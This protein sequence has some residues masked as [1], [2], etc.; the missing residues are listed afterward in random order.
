MLLLLPSHG[1]SKTCPAFCMI[2]LKQ[3]D[4]LEVGS[5]RACSHALLVQSMW[6]VLHSSHTLSM[7]LLLLQLLTTA[8]HVHCSMA[9]SADNAQL[10]PILVGQSSLPC[11]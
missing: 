1:P 5:R 10:N 7:L 8:F 6:T 11:T 2:C 4:W 9:C 3:T